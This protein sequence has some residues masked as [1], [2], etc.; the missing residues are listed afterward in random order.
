MLPDSHITLAVLVC[1]PNCTWLSRCLTGRRLT[2]H[3]FGEEAAGLEILC[4]TVFRQ[5]SHIQ[6]LVSV[7]SSIFNY[8]EKS[9]EAKLQNKLQFVFA[10]L[11]SKCFAAK[12]GIS[13]SCIQVNHQPSTWPAASSELFLNTVIFVLFCFLWGFFFL[14][15]L[16]LLFFAR[17]HLFVVNLWMN[18][19]LTDL[20]NSLGPCPIVCVLPPRYMAN[21]KLAIVHT[22]M[23]RKR[24]L[25]IVHPGQDKD[26]IPS[27]KV[28]GW[29]T[30]HRHRTH[31]HTWIPYLC[32]IFKRR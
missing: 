11:A 4:C 23:I 9:S 21:L 16:L 10:F 6:Q 7:S 25:P 15:L 27:Q 24:L 3:V 31:T 1:C 13:S 17:L 20:V 29:S 8:S 26:N 14:L 28:C 32:F 18:A 5:S 2:W 19:A 30:K 22:K 12:S